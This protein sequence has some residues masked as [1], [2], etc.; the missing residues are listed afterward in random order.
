MENNKIPTILV[1]DDNRIVK[2]FE[3]YFSKIG[4]KLIICKT[5]NEAVQ[6]I[7]EFINNERN[8]NLILDGKF[9]NDLEEKIEGDFK[10]SGDVV[11]HFV[12]EEGNKFLQKVIFNSGNGES[13]FSQNKINKLEI[14]N[15]IFI[16]KSIGFSDIKKFL[17]PN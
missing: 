10:S 8:F 14:K 11:L 17:Y 3:K 12:L 9:P 4:K 7:K 2:F 1:E 5:L 6:K 16:N 13:A 15:F